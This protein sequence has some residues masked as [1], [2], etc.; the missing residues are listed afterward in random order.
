MSIIAES[1]HME[2]IS[3]SA[4][5]LS[6]KI[7]DCSLQDINDF[8]RKFC[9]RTKWFNNNQH[10]IFYHK[11]TYI[12]FK[13]SLNNWNDQHVNITKVKEN[14]IKDAIHELAWLIDVDPSI[15]FHTVDNITAGAKLERSINLEDFVNEN[16]DYSDLICYNPESF[17]GLFVR[18]E[19]GKAILFRNGKLVFVGCKDKEQLEKL[20]SFIMK[21]CANI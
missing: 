9:I 11:Y 3:I 1:I 13:K 12:F 2:S 4:Y 10:L 18:G 16:Q 17:T 14:E 15:I 7:P 21:L 6:A 20:Y 5:K 8:C 19:N